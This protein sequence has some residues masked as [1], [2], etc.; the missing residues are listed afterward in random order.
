MGKRLE[1]FGEVR[2]VDE[3]NSFGLDF[4]KKT[5]NGYKSTSPD[6]GAV[7]ER[8]TYLG[9]AYSLKVKR[10]AEE[11]LD[12]GEISVCDR[13]G[14]RCQARIGLISHRRRCAPT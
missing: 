4:V 8:R 11:E 2:L 3:T 13:C 6:V 14:R 9:L 7:L 1:R 10:R 5:E 12:L